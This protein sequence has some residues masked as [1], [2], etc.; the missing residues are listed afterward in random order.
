MS[1]RNWDDLRELYLE[2]L[3]LNRS[4]S[5]HTVE[6]Y[7]RDILAFQ[8][9][10]RKHHL[11]RP[12]Q[13]TQEHAEGFQAHLSQEGKSS[14]SIV[15]AISAVRSF[16]RFLSRENL[17]DKN[18]KQVF[19]APRLSRGLPRALS[20]SQM[21][22]ILE[23]PDVE[24]KE[25]L[26]D[27]AILELFYA[28]GLRVSELVSLT[29]EALHTETG[30]LRVTGKGSKE[31]IVPVGKQALHWVERYVQRARGELDRG[32]PQKWLFL[33]NRGRA[34]TRQTVWHLLRKYARLSGIPSRVS[35]HVLR[36]SFATHLLEGGADLR[37]V[38]QMLGHATVATTQ[39]YTHLSR[40]HL[41]ETY[42]KFHPRARKDQT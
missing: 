3:R 14:R 39:I 20:A 35:P 4:L 13:I 6:A 24:K 21:I 25:G 41:R 15:R 37:S 1:N 36:H 8:T 23:A 32:K 5:P 9:Y 19:S 17:V 38:Q 2:G 31:R 40:R 28:S 16:Y 34:M 12:E 7:A 10:A 11:S 42:G 29:Y 26:R 30:L 33:S 18:V 22:K 27:R